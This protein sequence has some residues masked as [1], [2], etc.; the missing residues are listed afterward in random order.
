[1]SSAAWRPRVRANGFW[2]LSAGQKSAAGFAQPVGLESTAE[3][4][5]IVALLAQDSIGLLVQ[6]SLVLRSFFYRNTVLI[7]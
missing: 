6:P 3:F 5:R 1:M 7:T 4:S 2:E